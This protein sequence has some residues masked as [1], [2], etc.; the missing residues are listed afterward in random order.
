[1]N[2]T[3][4]SQQQ[5]ANTLG[6]IATFLLVRQPAWSNWKYSNLINVVITANSKQLLYFTLTPWGD[7]QS[8]CVCAES[9][10]KNTIEILQFSGIISD[11][12]K[13]LAEFWKVYPTITTAT[14]YRN[15]RKVKF[16]LTRL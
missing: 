7:L 5:N 9:N 2:A 12:R 1:M 10:E 8:V 11:L 14:F 3:T 15:K 13:M 4:I 6:D 16:D